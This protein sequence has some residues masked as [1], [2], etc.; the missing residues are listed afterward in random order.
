MEFIEKPFNFIQTGR[1]GETVGDIRIAE[2]AF[3]GLVV[4]VFGRC[5]I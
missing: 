1:S 4:R 3:R 5:A 2:P